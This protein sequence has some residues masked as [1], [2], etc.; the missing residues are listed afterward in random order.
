VEHLRSI[1]VGQYDSPYL[2]RVAITLRYCRLAFTRNPI[3]VFG[4]AEAMAKTNLLVRIPSL[5]LDDGEILID[6]GA[7]IRLP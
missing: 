7:I 5:V 2:R 6:S 3:C 4:D 1:L